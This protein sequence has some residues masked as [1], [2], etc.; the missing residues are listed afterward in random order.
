MAEPAQTIISGV[1][2]AAAATATGVFLGMYPD[3][4]IIGFVAG[5]VALLHVP[6][7]VGQRTPLRIFALVAGS[8]FLAG[9]FSPIASAMMVA[10]F[11]WAKPINEGSL[12]FAVA[13]CIGGGVHLPWVRQWFGRRLDK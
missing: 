7:E 10:Y 5:L 8:A 2:P 6:P 9:V 3:A 4:M 13:T 1:A 12:R 11:D